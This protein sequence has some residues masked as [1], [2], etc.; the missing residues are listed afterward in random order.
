MK[1]LT[2]TEYIDKQLK[3]DAEFAKHYVC[4]Q[5]IN[6]F[7]EAIKNNPD[8]FPEGYLTNLTAEEWEPLKSKFSTSTKGG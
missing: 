4:E 6:A 2:L 3:T 1:A 5:I 8:K 7:V